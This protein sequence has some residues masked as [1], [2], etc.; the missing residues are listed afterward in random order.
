MSS[1]DEWLILLHDKKEICDR[2]EQLEAIKLGLKYNLDSQT[3]KN[4]FKNIFNIFFASAS[5]P[6][7][8]GWFGWIN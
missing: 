4:V 8:N 7:L 3:V 6:Y 1:M 5:K 2:V